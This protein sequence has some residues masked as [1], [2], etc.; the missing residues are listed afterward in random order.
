MEKFYEWMQKI[1][2]V[3][4]SEMINSNEITE[5]IIEKFE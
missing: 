3:Y 1:N 5:R 4:Y 2:N